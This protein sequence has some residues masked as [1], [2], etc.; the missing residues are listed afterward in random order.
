MPHICNRRTKTGGAC[1][2]TVLL[3]GAS[4]F[5]HL[6]L[7]GVAAPAL[8]PT[9]CTHVTALG[10]RCNRR[11]SEGHSV[12]PSHTKHDV[13]IYTATDGYDPC[14][15]G[16]CHF[17]GNYDN[18]DGG[19]V[20]GAHLRP[21][22]IRIYEVRKLRILADMRADLR[23]D[24]GIQVNDLFLRIEEFADAWYIAE[25]T[26]RWLR[27]TLLTDV[28]MMEMNALDMGRNAPKNN[29]HRGTSNELALFA[30][31]SQNI[32][33]PR[34]V[35]FMTTKTDE[36]LATT[37]IGVGTEKKI[38]R[39]VRAFFPDKRVRDDIREWAKK[40]PKYKE[41]LVHTW[42]K[43]NN[44]AEVNKGDLIQR[45]REEITE[46]VGMCAQGHIARLCNVFAG[47]EET[48]VQVMSLQDRMAEISRIDGDTELKIAEAH[49]VFDE[50]N[51]PGGERAVWLEAF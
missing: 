16:N 15:V 35:D 51:V 17:A 13:I 7:E 46:S 45:F 18:L 49:R 43:I 21:E 24:D 20:C 5:Q 37:E 11:R 12:C 36:I 14:S 26:A 27:D 30:S 22:N 25:T 33:T 10:K 23:A 32:H 8:Q 28:V 29:D 9:K 3:D 6:E 38:M 42:A 19:A 34:V 47:F 31:D 1:R 40:E 39:E 48:P 50:M 4:C 41:L 2:R 44:S